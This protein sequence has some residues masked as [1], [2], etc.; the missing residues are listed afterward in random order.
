MFRCNSSRRSLPIQYSACIR[1]IAVYGNC[2]MSEER[3]LT[4]AIFKAGLTV[5]LVLGKAQEILRKLHIKLPVGNLKKAEICRSLIAI[6]VACSILNIQLDKAKLMAQ[7]SISPKLYQEGLINCKQVLKVQRDSDVTQ[8]LA[9]HFG[10][11]LKSS[12]HDVLEKYK[13][14]YIDKLHPNQRALVDIKSSVCQ[15]AAFYVVGIRN[16]VNILK[17]LIVSD[18]IP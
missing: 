4:D 14:D 6:E 8:K 16:K 1:H 11:H 17:H 5:H 13:R 12:V 7:V 9:V 10:F 3:Y 2:E 18:P 15:A